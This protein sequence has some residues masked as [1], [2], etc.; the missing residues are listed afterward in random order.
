MAGGRTEKRNDP[1]AEDL[2]QK[3]ARGTGL[4]RTGQS[5][6]TGRRTGGS[7]V[8]NAD[9]G[10]KKY[11]KLTRACKAVPFVPTPRRTSAGLLLCR[12]GRSVRPRFYDSNLNSA[13]QRGFHYEN[14]GTELS[15]GI[16]REAGGGRLK[17]I[18]PDTARP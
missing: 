13:V 5:Q 2:M 9:R 15:C 8:S 11:E 4:R 12:P 7:Y 1:V 18:A 16:P 10:R 17:S 3:A 6:E 14:Q